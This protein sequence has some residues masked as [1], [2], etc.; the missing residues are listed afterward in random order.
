MP[1]I[2]SDDTARSIS[3][4]ILR[5]TDH[6]ELVVR[7]P[8]G[9]E[10]RFGVVGS[11]LRGEIQLHDEGVW[12]QFLRGSLGV[13]ET[14]AEGRWSSPDLVSLVSL[15][16]RNMPAFDRLRGRFKHL[17]LPVQHVRNGARNTVARARRQISAHYDLSNDLFGL[18]LDPTMSYSCAVFEQPGTDLETAQVEKIDRLCRKLGL[19]PGMTLVEIGTGW[20]ALAIHAA[21]EY[22]VHVTTTTISREQHALARTRIDEAG[23]ADR[24]DLR[25]EDYRDL[26]GQYDRLVSVEMIEAVGWRDLPT[27][28]QRCDALLKH[29]G[30]MAVQAI[31]IDDGAYEIEKRQRSFIN[32]MIFPGGC[33]PSQQVMGR[34]V[35][36]DTR[37]R[38][39]DVEDLTPHYAETCARWRETFNARLADVRALGYDERFIRLWDLYL[40]Y[41]QA[42]FQERRIELVQEVYAAP[43]YAA[44][45]EQ[46]V[47]DA[48]TSATAAA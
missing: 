45:D 16:A 9:R 12:R 17:L 31:T 42:G 35:T 26:Q 36:S 29:N 39:V 43:G 18:F 20:G 33:L 8:D 44:A 6:G 30:L 5:A 27:F 19:E 23:L 48:R 24:I 21:R 40:A 47:R 13:G 37:L 34:L 2:L 38:T 25:L 46:R 7:E 41:V 3:L 15:G 28:Y 11:P 10:H 4:R 32:T 1:R 14:Y 22:G